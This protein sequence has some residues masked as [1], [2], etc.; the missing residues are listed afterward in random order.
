MEKC[1]ENEFLK[2][3]SLLSININIEFFN[4]SFNKHLL[5]IRTRNEKKSNDTL[6]LKTILAENKNILI[7]ATSIWSKEI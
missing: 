4:E 6:F 2:K 7:Q 1:A 3:A 5:D